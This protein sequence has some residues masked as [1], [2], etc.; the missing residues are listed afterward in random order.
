MIEQNYNAFK[1]MK[2]EIR[3]D[4]TYIQIHLHIKKQLRICV[5]NVQLSILVVNI[6]F[7]LI[8]IFISY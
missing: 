1:V 3:L 4:V 7:F 8:N 5:N 6:Q 2:I